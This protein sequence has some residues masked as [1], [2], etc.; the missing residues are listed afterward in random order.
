MKVSDVMTRDVRVA[1]PADTVA[2]V[3]RQMS[4]IDAGVVPIMNGDA[5][6]GVITD[7]DI[8][9][10]VVG[11]SRDSGIPVSQ[12]M[13]TPVETCRQ[14]EN[15]RDATRKMADLQMRRMVIVDDAGKLAGIL[16]L[17]DVALEESARSVGHALEKISE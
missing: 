5:I 9:I 4:E 7:R 15:L 6:L 2:Q 13:T 12:V 1:G 16:S 14:D 3:A 8:V 17:G 10:R 11:E